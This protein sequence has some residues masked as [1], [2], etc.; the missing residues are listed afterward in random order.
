MHEADTHN[1]QGRLCTA[2]VG[3][4]FAAKDLILAVSQRPR[5]LRISLFDSLELLEVMST[6]EEKP[7]H[8]FC[9]PHPSLSACC[10]C[11]VGEPG[12]A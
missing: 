11:F 9:L 12:I 1:G 7:R 3:G 10:A 8:Y 4:P 6:S 2:F 5:G